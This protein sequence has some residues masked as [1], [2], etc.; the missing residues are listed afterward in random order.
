MG[1]NG[2][3]TLDEAAAYS[4]VAKITLRRWARKGELPRVRIGKRGDR[5]FRQDD[6]NAYIRANRSPKSKPSGK[7]AARRGERP[8]KEA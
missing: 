4:G 8:P 3:V 5:C 6:L 2:S 1:D 7:G